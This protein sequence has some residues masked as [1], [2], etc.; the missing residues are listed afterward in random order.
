MFNYEIVEEK[1]STGP[2]ECNV[3]TLSSLEP[4]ISRLNEKNY[5]TVHAG[6]EPSAQEKA[7]S[8][9]SDYVCAWYE[10]QLTQQNTVQAPDFA[11]EEPEVAEEITPAFTPLQV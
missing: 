11:G 2:P 6:V 10:W 7:V 4:L 9:L 5:S 8:Q 1:I 3:D